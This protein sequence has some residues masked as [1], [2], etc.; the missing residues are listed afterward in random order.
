M[1]KSLHLR[2]LSE[3]FQEPSQ[4]EAGSPTSLGF[5]NTHL[6]RTTRGR[7]YCVHVARR[8]Q[9]KE[10]GEGGLKLEAEKDNGLDNC[11]PSVRYIVRRLIRDGCSRGT[12]M[13]KSYIVPLFAVQAPVDVV[14]W[15][16]GRYGEWTTFLALLIRAFFYIPEA[17]W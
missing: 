8:S 15:I 16:K 3:P 11:A 2:Y 10:S 1:A 4:P 7:G 5:K 14:S 17:V 12:A 13:P 6:S 9:K